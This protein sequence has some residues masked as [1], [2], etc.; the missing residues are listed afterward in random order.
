MTPFKFSLLD[1]VKFIESADQ[2]HTIFYHPGATWWTHNES[3][4]RVKSEV[5]WDQDIEAI[6][7]KI[8]ISEGEVKEGLEMLLPEVIKAR[9]SGEKLYMTPDGKMPQR[10]DV[11]TFIAFNLQNAGRLGKFGFITLM[12]GHHQNCGGVVSEFWDVFAEDCAVEWKANVFQLDSLRNRMRKVLNDWRADS[13]GG[14]KKLYAE[15][16]RAVILP[17]RN[18]VEIGRNDLCPCGSGKKYKVCHGA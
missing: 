9:D 6:Q 10:M 1:F 11:R 5:E 12:S 17:I 16:K 4:L 2:K 7:N 15:G 14:A 3:D 8:N 13:L 18:T